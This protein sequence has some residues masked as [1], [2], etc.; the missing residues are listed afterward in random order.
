MNLDHIIL[1]LNSDKRIVIHLRINKKE[2]SLLVLH[3]AHYIVVLEP[4]LSCLK[5]GSLQVNYINTAN[6]KIQSQS[7]IIA[8]IRDID[9]QLYSLNL[10]RSSLNIEKIKELQNTRESNVKQL[11]RLQNMAQNSRKYRS[12]VKHVLQIAQ[13]KSGII[14]VNDKRGRRRLE[15][16]PEMKI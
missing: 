8:N 5:L 1:L 3:D 14:L 4:I 15:D 6:T 7:S 10:L 13:D 11:K 2:H 9:T 16:I 12:K